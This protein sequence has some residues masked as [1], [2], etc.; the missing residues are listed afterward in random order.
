MTS[1]SPSSS[2]RGRTRLTFTY[3]RSTA[4][5]PTPTVNITNPVGGA[6]F[7]APANVKIAASASVSSGAVTNVAF[8]AGATALGSAT[9]PPFGI[10]ASNLAANSYLLTA[11][12][13]AAGVSATSSVVNISVVSPVA[14]SNSAPAI[15]GGQFSFDYS[16]NPG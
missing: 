12:A 3:K 1:T 8:F 2:P 9:V 15:I 14:V 10:T 16:V 5:L 11:V 6:V 4:P 7:A 13:T